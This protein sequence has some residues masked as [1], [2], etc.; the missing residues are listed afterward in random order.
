MITKFVRDRYWDII[1][2][3]GRFAPKNFGEERTNN[4]FSIGIVTYVDRYNRFFKPLITH[5]VTIFPD[6]EFVICINGY[7]DKEIQ[8]NY[9]NDIKAFLSKF[10]NVKI[11]DFIE[12]QSLSKLWNLLILNSSCEKTII[13]NDD[14]KISPTFR[15]NLEC[16]SFLNE[17][18]AL[19]NR[20]WSHFII[21]KKT[22]GLVGWFDQRLPGVGNEDED[23]ECRLVQN[24]IEIKSYKIKGLKNITYLTTNFSYG[25]DVPIIELKYIKQNKVF[26]DSKW[27]LSD[28][29]LPDYIYVEII[30]KYVRLKEGMETPWFYDLKLLSNPVINII[31]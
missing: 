18:F 5:L 15:K 30:K 7:Y 29:D 31:K 21:S 6:N 22:V 11:V 27:E 25:K 26:F 17:E 23:Y 10:K 13:L 14:L 3:G 20:V 9:L 28:L 16:T 2:L 19:I 4:K 12:P 1:M 8:V 24:K